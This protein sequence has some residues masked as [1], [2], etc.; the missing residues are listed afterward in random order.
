MKILRK[1]S[2][3]SKFTGSYLK[4]DSIPIIPIILKPS[5]N[6]TDNR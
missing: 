5:D 6:E 1:A 2:L 4:E 3:G